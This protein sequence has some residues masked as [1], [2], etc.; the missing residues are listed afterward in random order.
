MKTVVWFLQS[1]T[2]SLNTEKRKSTITLTSSLE[3]N[4]CLSKGN[5]LTLLFSRLPNG[6]CGSTKDRKWV[7]ASLRS[8]NK[9]QV[10]IHLLTTNCFLA[11]PADDVFVWHQVVQEGLQ[12]VLPLLQKLLLVVVSEPAF[13][14]QDQMT[15]GKQLF[16]LQSEQNTLRC[17]QD[18]C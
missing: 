9:S 5:Y 7:T 18:E 17:G 4:S 8:K 14:R 15:A 12:S 1:L 3:G 6:L 13:G 10:Q 16:E 11:A 2:K